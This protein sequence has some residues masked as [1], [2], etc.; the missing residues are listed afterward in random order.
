MA[1][2]PISHTAD[3]GFKISSATLGGLFEE[4]AAAFTDCLVEKGGLS[5]P[6]TR[7]TFRLEAASLEELLV[8]WLEELLF[9]FETK[10]LVGVTFDV[11]HCEIKNFEAEVGLMEWDEKDQPLKTQ[12]KAVTYHGLQVKK[13]ERGFEAQII[14]DV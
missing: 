8:T 7:Q 14:L 9:L 3:I 4:A 6:K 13:T 2:R 11:K 12:V 5:V 1:T 10:G